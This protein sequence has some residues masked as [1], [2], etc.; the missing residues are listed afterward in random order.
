MSLSGLS[1]AAKN[2]VFSDDTIS[3]KSFSDNKSVALYQLFPK[4]NEVKGVLS[5]GNLFSVKYWSCNHY[6]KHSF[7][8]IGPEMQ[9]IP[10]ELNSQVIFLGGVSLSEAE[11]NLLVKAIERK[12]LKLS[13]LP[14][15]LN[16]SSDGF[17]EF[18]IQIG[19]AGE[20]IFVEIKLYKG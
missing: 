10:D 4:K 5:N 6:G 8:I 12:P 7:M 3:E 13:N 9:T 17:N 14:I 20:A 18:Y 11:L 15:K 16:I 1:C 19:I 2:C